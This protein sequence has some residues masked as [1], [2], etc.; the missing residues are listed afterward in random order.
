MKE[1]TSKYLDFLGPSTSEDRN[2][3]HKN[4]ASTEKKKKCFC[5]SSQLAANGEPLVPAVLGSAL[6]PEAPLDHRKNSRWSKK[7]TKTN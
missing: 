7:H 4:L 5:W 1:D 6:A 3:S 2:F